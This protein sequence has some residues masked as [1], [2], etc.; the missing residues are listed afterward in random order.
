M[1]QEIMQALYR[2]P[3]Y[4]YH[5]GLA[6]NE[7]LDLISNKKIK[8]VEVNGRTRIPYSE[9]ERAMTEGI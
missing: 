2:I 6:G 4:A 5:T 3:Q 7:V 1:P 9:L 8:T